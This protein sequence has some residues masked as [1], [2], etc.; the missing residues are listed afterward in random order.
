MIR[1]VHPGSG[2]VFFTFIITLSLNV[3]T[4]D[5][6]EEQSKPR[7]PPTKLACEFCGKKFRMRPSLNKHKE[8]QHRTEIKNSRSYFYSHRS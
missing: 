1:V 8:R 5:V 2:S 4:T 7:L 3:G 6:A